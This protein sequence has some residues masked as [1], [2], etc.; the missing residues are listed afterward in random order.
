MNTIFSKI[1][2][3]SIISSLIFCSCERFH[4]RSNVIEASQSILDTAQRYLVLA[5]DSSSAIKDSSKPGQV[6]NNK[7]PT[8]TLQ[9]KVQGSPDALV[10]YAITLEGTPYAYGKQDPIAGFD[11]SG[12]V[13]YV[14]K[15]FSVDVPRYT[16]EF[17][18]VG[19]SIT[20]K[21]AGPGDLILFSVSDSSKKTIAH[22]GII[23]SEVGKP[24]S[25]IH[26]TSGK[27]RGVVV[28]KM[29]SYY[30]KRLMGIR[31]LFR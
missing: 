13:N 2:L 27:F 3:L 24:V 30:Q 7:A 4:H 8:D 12:F 29:N 15:H 31:T 11:N 14:Y 20:E 19:R 9:N 26:A 5:K 10:A 1:L 23:T 22:V 25:F 17:A 18:K 6:S 16:A 28:T 21:E